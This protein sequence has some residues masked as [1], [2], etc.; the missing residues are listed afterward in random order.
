MAFKWDSADSTLNTGYN[1]SATSLQVAFTTNRWTTN[2]A[3][4]P[5][6]IMIKREKMTVTNIT[7]TTSPQTFTVTRSV[8]GVAKSHSA[9]E[10]VHLADVYYWGRGN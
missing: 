10:E 4:F 2:A 8:N 3:H 6:N 9:G 1:T 5:F 7:G